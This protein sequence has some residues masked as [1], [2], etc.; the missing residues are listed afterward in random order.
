[1]TG[2]ENV[3]NNTWS[4]KLNLGIIKFRAP[5]RTATLSKH[6]NTMFLDTA[7]PEKKFAL[8]KGSLSDLLPMDM[9]H[10]IFMWLVRLKHRKKLNAVLLQL[11]SPP[12]Y[13]LCIDANQAWK[14]TLSF[15]NLNLSLS[16]QYEWANILT[17]GWGKKYQLI[18]HENG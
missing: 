5:G 15:G 11:N 8:R 9:I 16:N 18:K 17:N 12:N 2:K 13:V 3:P 7:C 10:N 4:T 6:K 14:S 1:M